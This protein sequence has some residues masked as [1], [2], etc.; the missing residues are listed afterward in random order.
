MFTEDSRAENAVVIGAGTM[1]GGIA[2]QLA[3]VGWT[4]HLLDVTHGAA[5]AGRARVL[6]HEPPLLFVPE[7]SERIRTGSLAKAS[8][9][10]RAADWIIEAASENMAIKQVILAQAERDGNPHA[11]V[12]SNTSGLS[13]REM[14]AHCPPEF[15]SRFLGAHFLNPPRYLKLLEVIP[16]PETDTKLSE[17]FVS[18]AERVLGHR[19]IIARDTP[20]FISTRLGIWHLLDSIHTALEWGLTPEESDAATSPLLG[21]PRT[22]TFRLAD[23][24]GLDILVAISQDLYARLPDDPARDRLLLPLVVQ[25]LI[26]DGRTGDK[27]GAGF[28][29]RESK[30]SLALDLAT[31]EYRPRREIQDGALDALMQLPLR[32][33][34]ARLESDGGRLGQYAKRVLKSLG[35]YISRVGPQIADNATDIDR[36]MQWGFGWELG[37]CEVSRIAFGT[38]PKENGEY[39]TLA[40][41]KTPKT[42]VLDAPE[43]S[44]VDIGD[45]VACLEFHTKL[46]TFSSALTAFVDNARQRAER[47]FRALVIASD[48]RNFSAGYDL[49]LFLQGAEKGDWA[50][51]DQQL[52]EVQQAFLGLKYARVPVVA[53][54]RGYTL[55]AG[56]E[57]VLH[58]AAVVAAPELRIGLPEF[59]VG[60]LP[61]GGGTKEMLARAM[62]AGDGYSHVERVFD[63][64]TQPRRSAS[65]EE[66]Q[67]TGFLRP[68]DI[69]ERN[70]DRLLSAAKQRAL[71]LA[72]DYQP[73]LLWDIPVGGAE[74]LA[75]LRLR[76]EEQ[77]QAGTWTDYDA[78]IAD[79]VAWVVSGGDLTAPAV[80]SEQDLLDLER[81]AFVELMRRPETAARMR[82]ILATGKPLRN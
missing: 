39:M 22:G 80:V 8:D 9:A 24:I 76:I 78:V 40:K 70:G 4:V 52:R 3:N 63:R 2:A 51:L 27:A 30:Y 66:A 16:L 77:R 68:S 15:R 56:C 6:A 82:Q 50:G 19:V 54:P 74:I 62:Q 67:R 46:N 17:S 43:A 47:D 33:R 57:C 73:P 65:A 48:A 7:F 53:A 41:M 1:G 38:P 44:L 13:L 71:E 69:I 18:F 55:G 23:H 5:E 79:R 61:A 60:V 64:L 42:T 58:C 11:L 49:N 21:R 32:E 14:T 45:G 34:L 10:L 72:N 81:A 12:S 37:P 29:K 25:S 36:T 35:E 20:G 28:Y 31:L 59:H 75:R 26:A